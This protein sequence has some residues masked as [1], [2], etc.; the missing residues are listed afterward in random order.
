GVPAQAQDLGAAPGVPDH[1]LPGYSKPSRRGGGEAAAVG[2]EA[3]AAHL[4]GVPAQ[5]QE[6]RAA[7]RGPD[8]NL[9][10][11]VPLPPPPGAG[12]AAAVG[13]VTDAVHRV[14]APA[15]GEDLGAC[16]RVPDLDAVACAQG[17]APAVGAVAEVV[18]GAGPPAGVSEQG[19][20]LGAPAT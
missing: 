16:A 3:D 12:D 15:H 9:T 19:E 4:P 1:D 13:A 20:D 7:A 2:A 17:H 6:V 5:G 18:A 8:F 14:V 10:R 11:A